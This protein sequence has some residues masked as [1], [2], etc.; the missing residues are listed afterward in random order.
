MLTHLSVRNFAVVEA[1]E[2]GFG[3]G[4]TVVTGETGAGKSLLVDALLLLAGTRADTGMVRA[5]CER[6]ELSA[7]F[8]LAGGSGAPE[9]LADQ[10]L[11]DEDGGCR[12]RRV[13]A[14]EGG[15][16][17]WINGRAVSL[18]QLSELAAMLVTR[19]CSI[20]RGSCRCWTPPVAATT[21]SPGCATWRCGIA[22]SWRASA[23]CPVATTARPASSCCAMN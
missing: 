22:R 1:A 13:I 8:D 11:D 10:A 9:W 15:S 7:D 23:N 21:P 3:P 4:L 2:L 14:A 16:R 6:A 12:V 19:R 20:A 17:T 5:G 18:A